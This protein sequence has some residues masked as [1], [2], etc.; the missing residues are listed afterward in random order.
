MLITQMPEISTDVERELPGVNNEAY[1]Y[2]NNAKD[3]IKKLL[4]ASP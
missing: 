3:K 1:M 2:D 4:Q